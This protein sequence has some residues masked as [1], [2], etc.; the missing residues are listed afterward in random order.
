MLNIQFSSEAE[1]DFR[2]SFY[3]YETKKEGLGFQFED[4]ISSCLQKISEHPEY[5]GTTDGGLR[6]ILVQ[7][8]PYVIAFEPDVE[9]GRILV[10]SIAHTSRD[11]RERYKR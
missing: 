6:R 1:A 3:Y 5:Y 11:L 10:V 4:A 9:A 2:E 8:F 7:T